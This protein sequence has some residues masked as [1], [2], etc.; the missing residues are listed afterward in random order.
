VCIVLLVCEV[1]HVH[2]DVVLE[3]VGAVLKVVGGFAVRHRRI[4]AFLYGRCCCGFAPPMLQHEAVGA[5]WVCE[6]LLDPKVRCQ[7]QF[8]ATPCIG[9][10]ISSQARCSASSHG[11]PSSLRRLR[12]VVV[13]HHTTP[14][15]RAQRPLPT[16]VS[17]TLLSP[18]EL[19]HAVKTYVFFL[20]VR[21]SSTSCSPAAVRPR[22]WAVPAYRAH[23]DLTPSRL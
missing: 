21:P 4:V 18:A 17:C 13:A 14:Q 2:C 5:R 3:V 22:R 6:R 7:G 19:A 8:R 9:I 10:T 12:L 15:L 16:Q 1:W 11:T 20:S 23:R